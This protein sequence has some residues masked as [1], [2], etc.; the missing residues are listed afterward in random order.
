MAIF[1]YFRSGV[2]NVRVI[3]R[4]SNLFSPISRAPINIKKFYFLDNARNMRVSVTWCEKILSLSADFHSSNP[5][6][7]WF[8]QEIH[9][10]AFRTM[11]FS[12]Y[13]WSR[14]P[15]VPVVCGKSPRS[16][17]SARLVDRLTLD[18]P[19]F[20]RKASRS[21]FE[22]VCLSIRRATTCA[23]PVAEHNVVFAWPENLDE[24][25]VNVLLSSRE[26]DGKRGEAVKIEFARETGLRL[27]WDSIRSLIFSDFHRF[28]DATLGYFSYSACLLRRFGGYTVSRSYQII[29]VDVGKISRDFRILHRSHR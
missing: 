19:H 22:H 20:N 17:L 25:R 7:C 5:W 14:G 6:P 1:W 8:P 4:W 21:L 24:Q 26:E 2:I 23:Q 18:W 16:S 11:Y 12:R 3:H 9:W 29:R 27:Y 28:L 13:S 15:V 10:I